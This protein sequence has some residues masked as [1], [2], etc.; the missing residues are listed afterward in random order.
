MQNDRSNFKN[1]P[2][3]RVIPVRLSQLC[4]S[5]AGAESRNP[6][7]GIAA[8]VLTITDQVM[9]CCLSSSLPRVKQ[10]QPW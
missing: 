5:R 9:G 2:I 8:A 3:V 7:D 6:L 4:H 1:Q 10:N